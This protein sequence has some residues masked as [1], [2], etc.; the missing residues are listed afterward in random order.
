MIRHENCVKNAR[1]MIFWRLRAPSMRTTWTHVWKVSVNVRC[2][3]WTM[4]KNCWKKAT[5]EG[6]VWSLKPPLGSVVDWEFQIGWCNWLHFT[7]LNWWTTSHG[8]RLEPRVGLIWFPVSLRR[9]CIMCHQAAH[10]SGLLQYEGNQA[11]INQG[12]WSTWI[13]RS[14]TNQYIMYMKGDNLF[15]THIFRI[16][17]MILQCVE[18][19]PF[20]FIIPMIAPVV[21]PPWDNRSRFR[22]CPMRQQACTALPLGISRSHVVHKWFGNGV[23]SNKIGGWSITFGGVLSVL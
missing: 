19:S 20:I 22:F 9:S 1:V 18:S 16:N 7:Q 12:T 4:S 17:P 6:R 2:S 5:S 10:M 21:H 11:G 14:L 23:V 15:F 8:P 13:P 3:P